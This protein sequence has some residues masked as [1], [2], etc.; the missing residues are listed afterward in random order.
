MTNNKIEQL[1][2]LA[3]VLIVALD[4]Y[5][6]NEAWID[7]QEHDLSLDNVSDDEYQRGDENLNLL[8]GDRQKLKKVIA[9]HIENLNFVYTNEI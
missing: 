4:A 6:L 7:D 5:K 1:K 3:E 2:D 9:S 8:L